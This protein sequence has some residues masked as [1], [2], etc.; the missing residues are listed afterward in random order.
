M[1]C[2]RILCIVLLIVQPMCV[3]AAETVSDAEFDALLSL[4]IDQLTVTSVSKT[5]EK[6]SGAA[7]AIYVIT[8]EDLRR[9]GV[10]SVVEALRIVPGTDVSQITAHD[11]M[12]SV[13]SLAVPA[14]GLNADLVSKLLVLVDGR[15]VYTPIRSLVYWDMEDMIISDI[16]RIEVIRGPGATLWGANAVNGVINIV[17]KHAKD[18]QGTYLAA[19][20][21]T[22]EYLTTEGRYGGHSGKDTFY[23]VY[24]KQ[25]K[26]GPT[27]LAANG[28]DAYD[29]WYQIRTGFR[30]DSGKEAD[31]YTV[32]GDI[33]HGQ[34][35]EF[36]NTL[37][38]T[39]PFVVPRVFTNDFNNM[40]IITR[41]TREI[42]DDAQLTAQWYLTHYNREAYAFNQEVTIADIDV[43]NAVYTT[44]RN[45]IV[46]GGGYRYTTD[47]MK[48]GPIITIQEARKQTDVANLFLQDE[49]AIIP[50]RLFLTLGSKY[51]YNDYT[52]NEVQP[53][54][55]VSYNIKHG[56]TVWGAVSRAVRVPSRAEND[57]DFI[58]MI[59]PSS[60]QGVINVMH[61]TSGG[62]IKSEELLAHELGYRF[63]ASPDFS[64]DINGYYNDYKNLTLLYR[65]PAHREG[66]MNVIPFPFT[67][68]G[69]GYTYGA[70]ISGSWSV[71]SWWKIAGSYSYMTLH[72]DSIGEGIVNPNSVERSS[73]HH[74][75]SLRSYMNIR[76]NLEWNVMC[77]FSDDLPDSANGIL[78]SVSNLRVDTKIAY[79]LL[80]TMEMSMVGRNLFN[81]AHAEY[82]MPPSTKIGPSILGE[83]SWGF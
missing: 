81:R 50:T 59:G 12:A 26:Y 79:K 55:R 16:D 30:V 8:E 45:Q 43:Q 72:I 61:I 76:P 4:D 66:N 34:E 31:N 41:W 13:H 77:Y 71:N 23:R 48:V 33:A 75:F 47:Y 58:A 9:L 78:Q 35:K 40:N 38:V 20:T 82:I 53:S 28:R 68:N 60:E 57:L 18:T 62:Y 74:A 73:P 3:V 21:G 64:I 65:A 54:V 80:P 2:W 19:R 27:E 69:S 25:S 24:A 11:W 63:Y 46:W 51:E 70:D 6:V 15:S 37:Q 5:S 39:S 7:A 83:I 42:S 14:R 44:G 32:Q 49:Y 36:T 22:E 52:Q 67:N 10:T 17:T 1:L 56:H 29:D